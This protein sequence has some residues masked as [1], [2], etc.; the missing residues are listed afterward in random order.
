METKK[1]SIFVYIDVKQVG[2]LYKGFDIV[3]YNYWACLIDMRSSATRFIRILFGALVQI[4]KKDWKKG[5][6]I[7]IEQ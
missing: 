1:N 3:N 6:V 4:Y 7:I 5:N 2:M